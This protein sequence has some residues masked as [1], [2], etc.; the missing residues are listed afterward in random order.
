VRYETRDEL[1]ERMFVQRF[2]HIKWRVQ[3]PGEVEIFQAVKEIV[4]KT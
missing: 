4:W 2:S 3:Q 1:I